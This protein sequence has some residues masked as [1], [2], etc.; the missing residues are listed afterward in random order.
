MSRILISGYY[1]FNNAGDD[2]VL[3]GIISALR[4]EQPNMSLAVLS[5][6]P[7]RTTSLFGIPAYNRWSLPVILR[8]LMK[9]DMLV[10]GGG[11]LMQDVTS[12]RSVL[13]Y[14]GIVSIAKMLGKPVVFYAQGFGPILKPISRRLIKQ[15]VNRVDVITVRDYESGDDFQA[16]GVTKAP[17]YVTADP[18]MTI[19]PDD[20]SSDRGRELLQALFADLSKP[21]VAIS[22]RDWKQEQAFKEVIA[23]ASDLFLDKGWNVLFLP[24]HYPSDLAPSREIIGM[25]NRPGAKLL[26]E[27]VTFHDIMSVLKQCD[28]VVGMRLHSLILACMLQTPF[29]GISYDPKIDRFVERA[30]MPCAG[31]ITQLQDAELLSLLEERISQLDREKAIIREHSE[32]LSREAAKSSELVLQALRQK[33]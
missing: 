24:M 23:R 1:G 17:I 28:Y 9:S 18:A 30:G 6:Q 33:K 11:T 12:P 7:E 31:H 16:C 29:T 15:V 8:E 20:I 4:R 14:L 2:V 5:N 25:M 27:A 13:Y 3:Y 32:I 21:L 19:S 22:V 26:D 10:M